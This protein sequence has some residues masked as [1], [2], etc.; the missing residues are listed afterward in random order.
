MAIVNTNTAPIL[1]EGTNI[2]LSQVGQT[3]TITS[4]A[5]S[6]AGGDPT[7]VQY[8]SGGASEGDPSFTYNDTTNVV[9]L[10]S[11]DFATTPAATDAERRLKWDNDEG[12]LVL[13]LKG[14]NVSIP[15]GA[16]VVSLVYNA[17]ATT[18]AKGEVVY[19]FGASGQRVSVK[20]AVNTSDATSAQTFGII[21]ESIAAGAEGFCMVQ[22]MVRGI[23]TSAY[24][25]GDPIYLGA[26]AGQFTKTKP[27]A[28]NHLVYLGF[29]VKVNASSGEIFTRPQNGYEMDE[30]HDYLEGS[31]QN[32]DVISYETSSGL[33]KPKSIPTLLG[34]TP[35]QNPMTTYGDM[36]YGGVDGV[37]TRRSGRTLTSRG[38]LSQNGDGTT[39][40]VPVWRRISLTTDVDDTLSYTQGGTGLSTL[41]LSDQVLKVNATQD[42]LEFGSI[43]SIIS[44]GIELLDGTGLSWVT[45]LGGASNASILFT[46]GNGIAFYATGTANT[47][48]FLQDATT[49]RVGIG[50][51]TPSAKLDVNG[52]VN[53]STIN[54]AT[55]DTDKFLVSDGGII[56]YRT[57]TEILSD[58]GAIGGSGTSAYIPYFTGTSTLGQSGLYWNQSS[59]RFGINITA[60]THTLDVNGD[61]RIRT[62]PYATIGTDY[63]IVANAA[64]SIQYRTANDVLNDIGGAATADVVTLST[65]QTI[66]GE[67]TFSLVVKASNG[68]DIVD[69]Q[70]IT[71]RAAGFGTANARISF[72]DTTGMSLYS[73]GVVTPTM[74]LSDDG[75]RRVGIGTTTPS[76]RLSVKSTDTAQGGVQNLIATIGDKTF[77]STND[78]SLLQAGFSDIGSIYNCFSV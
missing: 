58:I 60:V 39:P 75:N 54:N 7:E 17:E 72:T 28:P 51:V 25:Q 73:G 34:Y 24:T 5:G 78:A 19:A 56:K 10:E 46:N 41:G 27:V 33:Y 22:G 69:G 43:N 59:T 47:S 49:R 32:N 50:T 65:S 35:M 48:L 30:I 40:N 16:E 21:A 66:S 64:G 14:G 70:D 29:V 74:F 63:F 61:A 15:L 11:I 67:K 20:R 8:N 13:T 44:N 62:I 31:V 38:F 77:W 68:L 9:S 26:T 3:I 6:A 23:D 76:A 12:S 55:T 71:W 53:I 37:P 18:L 52:D 45:T 36:I 2:T 57:G 1:K 42:A 4:S